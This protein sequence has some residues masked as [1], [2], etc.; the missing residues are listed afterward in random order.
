MTTQR[1]LRSVPGASMALPLCAGLR[2]AV[3]VFDEPSIL[4]INASIA[5][6]RPL[7]VRGEPGTGKSQLARA[8][9]VDLGRA[10]LVHT[11]DA[12]TETRD[13]LW[14]MDAVSRLAEAQLLGALKPGDIADA[15]ETV[16]VRKF[17]EPRSLWWA[18]DWESARTQATEVRQTEPERPNGW[19]PELGVVLL[20]DEIDKAD[21]SVP[22]GLLDALGNERFDTPIG[23]VRA[24]AKPLVVITTN[25]ERALPDAFLRRCL[26]LSLALPEK[27]DELI[28]LLVDRGRAHDHTWDASVLWRAAEL[29]AD[30]RAA[31]SNLDLALPGTAEYLD[32]VR[33]VTVQHPTDTEAQ[34]ALLEKVKQF[35]LR[36]HPAG[37][38]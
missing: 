18:F 36:K 16:G 28:K 8:A 25:E 32:L 34:L 17:V 24:R 10:F 21:P 22:N 23:V 19:N 13:I 4:A 31:M 1:F 38:R 15:R 33:A 14:N 9:A 30:D 35:A 7:L 27:R 3:H 37:S 12:H 6:G 20:I 26:V 11:V 5:A 29:L 2:E